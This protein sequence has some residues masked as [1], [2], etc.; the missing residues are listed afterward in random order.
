MNTAQIK[1][2]IHEY[3]DYADER[4]LRL[5]YSMVESEHAETSFFTVPEEEMV[6]RAKKSL[7]SIDN[8]HTRSIHAFKKD[9]DT[10]KKKR[11][12]Q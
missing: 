10:W 8:G 4:F 9:V 11:A 2:R 7:Q 5:V 12:I 6:K 3:I 1:K